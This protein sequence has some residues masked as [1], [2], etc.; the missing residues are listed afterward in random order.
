MHPNL[1]RFPAWSED[2]PS[3]HHGYSAC[4]LL[5]QPYSFNH[6]NI[7]MLIIGASILEELIFLQCEHNLRWWFGADCIKGALLNAIIQGTRRVNPSQLFS[8]A[9]IANIMTHS[10]LVA[11]SQ[12]GR[13]LSYSMP[14]NGPFAP[15]EPAAAPI[16]DFVS[17]KRAATEEK[18]RQ[19]PPVKCTSR[20]T[21]LVIPTVN[22]YY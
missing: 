15:L 18:Q 17:K 19:G 13:Q 8:D 12:Q 11:S 22:F 5:Q 7:S 4:Q 2:C 3:G 1:H 10:L 21:I 9:H 20:V 14:W 16:A 6:S